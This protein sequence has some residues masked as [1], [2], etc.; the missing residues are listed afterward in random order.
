MKTA[1]SLTL[2]NIQPGQTFTHQIRVFADK[3]LSWGRCWRPV[4]Q[5]GGKLFV[6]AG[7][8]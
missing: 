3:I 7:L 1:Q 2:K 8:V 4:E 6:L 5:P